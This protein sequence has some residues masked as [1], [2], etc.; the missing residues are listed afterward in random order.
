MQREPTISPPASTTPARCEATCMW[1][2]AT[3]TRDRCVD[4]VSARWRESRGGQGGVRVSSRAQ[5]RTVITSRE[6]G[7]ESPDD[8]AE[9]SCGGDPSPSSRLRLTDKDSLVV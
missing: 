4:R 6:D 7:E 5:Y 9:R 8:Y 3:A 1:Q 2:A